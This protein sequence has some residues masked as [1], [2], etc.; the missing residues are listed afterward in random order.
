MPTYL[1]PESSVI[2]CAGCGHDVSGLL[3]RSMSVD[4]SCSCGAPI[5]V[6]C[7][8]RDAGA[9]ISGARFHI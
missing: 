9:P 4:V 8:L 5:M 1:N 3:F 2:P 6:G 7:A